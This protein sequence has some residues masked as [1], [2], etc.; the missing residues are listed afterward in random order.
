MTAVDRR[1]GLLR[2]M[3]ERSEH[4]GLKAS[5]IAQAAWTCQWIGGRPTAKMVYGAKYREAR[6]RDDLKALEAQGY[7]T[8]LPGRPARWTATTNRGDSNG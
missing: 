7:V 8:R 1:E 6:C 4:E 3:R 2:W 5:H